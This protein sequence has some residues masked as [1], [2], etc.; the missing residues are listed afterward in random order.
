MT[1]TLSDD[2]RQALHAEGTPL[3]LIDPVT[4]DAYIVVPESVYGAA[5]GNQRDADQELKN[6]QISGA[7]LKQLADQH[8]PPQQ[9]YDSEEEDLFE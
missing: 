2:L 9:W 5:L 7:R 3:R 8:R 6:A 4:G 1:L